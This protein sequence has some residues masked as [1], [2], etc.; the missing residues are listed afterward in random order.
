[1]IN[2][3][4]HHFISPVTG[5]VLLDRNLVFNGDKRGVATPSSVLVDIRLDV[6]YL[7]N[8]ITAQ[9]ALNKDIKFV[10]ETADARVPNA[11]SLD[12]IDNG[13]LKV[14]SGVLQK[15]TS[16]KNTAN[17]FVAPLD[18][19]EEINTTKAYAA[20]EAATA[21]ATAIAKFDAEMLPYVPT[22][23]YSYGVQITAAIA[24]AVMAESS[25]INNRISELRANLTGDVTGNGLLPNIV[26]AYKENSEFKGDFIKTPHQ[27]IIE[28]SLTIPKTN[29]L[30]LHTVTLE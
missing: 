9:A 28:P 2:K 4:L 12:L 25:I 11:Q 13:I 7:K 21:L 26:T 8:L 22:P 18:L 30:F 16:G 15:A 10:V 6:I 19:Q 20:S 14:M 1:M 17:D 29:C 24:A 27:L 3:Y 5:R 23:G